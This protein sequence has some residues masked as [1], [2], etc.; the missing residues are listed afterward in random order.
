MELEEHKDV[1]RNVFVS[2]LV[3]FVIFVFLKGEN[4]FIFPGLQQKFL[5]L[6]V[7]LG[8]LTGIL[9]IPFEDVWDWLESK[10]GKRKYGRKGLVERVKEKVFKK[11][12]KRKK[13]KKK[14]SWKREDKRRTWINYIFQGVL[15]LFLVLL[16]LETI[17]E[18]LIPGWLDLNYLM[19]LVIFFGVVTVL[20][21]PPEEKPWKKR[22]KE[23]I[24]KKDYILI[25]VLGIMGGAIVWYKTK[26]IGWISYGISIIS[27]ILIVLL[28][29]L[30]LEE[31]EE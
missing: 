21:P 2:L 24:T 17:K 5:W 20:F 26:E 1:V 13:K 10:F 18:G 19:G 16:L 4:P 30:I 22:G 9:Y 23:E 6:I 27:G 14:Y 31:D 29:I 7:A 12:K 8:V 3:L 28:S 11:K 25:G 15:V